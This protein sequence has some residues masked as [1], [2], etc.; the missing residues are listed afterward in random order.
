MATAG[1]PQPENQ[2]QISMIHSISAASAGVQLR[3]ALIRGGE[4]IT[5]SINGVLLKW[6]K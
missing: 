2:Q 5:H 4:S 6:S 3:V 1:L